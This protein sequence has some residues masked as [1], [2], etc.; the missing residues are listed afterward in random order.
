MESTVKKHINLH[1]AGASS[2]QTQPVEVEE[3]GPDLYRV[4]FSP[5]L[6]EGTA[7]GDLIRITD[8]SSGSFEVIEHGGNVSVKWAADSPVGHSLAKADDLLTRLGSR[9]D[10]A[11]AEAAVWT[12]P[13]SVGFHAIETQMAQVVALIPGSQWWYGNVYDHAGK[14]LN[15]W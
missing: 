14:P 5:G 3:V 8:V 11:I 2:G 12:I 4:L 6:V 15:W 7:A 13:V 9:R 10:G 1:V